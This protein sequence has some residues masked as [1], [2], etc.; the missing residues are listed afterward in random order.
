[1]RL[2]AKL[3]FVFLAVVMLMTAVGSYFSVRRGFERFERRQQQIARETADAIDKRLAEAW[4]QGGV[5]NLLATMQSLGL[6]DSPHRAR[7]V[8]FEQTQIGSGDSQTTIFEQRAAIGGGTV[9]KTF[10]DEHGER[11]LRTYYPIELG[12]SPRGGLEITGSLEPL[13]AA[14]RETIVTALMSLGSMAI[15]CVVLVYFA[16]VRWVAK[17]LDRLIVKTERIGRGDFSDPLPVCGSDELSQ[18]ARALNDMSAKLAEQQQRIHDESAERLATLEQLRHADRLKT[19]GRL[20]AGLAHELGTPLNV[21]SGRAGLIA[22]GKLSVDEIT[23]SANTIKSEADRVTAT[24]RQLLDFARPSKSQRMPVDL[25]ELLCQTIGLLE[26]LAENRNVQ[27][28]ITPSSGLIVSADRSQMLQV[29]TNLLVNAVQSMSA[30]GTIT[31]SVKPCRAKSAGKE[32]A[33][34]RNCVAVMIRDQGT[35]IRPEDLESI[36]EPFFTTKDVGEGTGL[37]LSI[38]YGIVQEHGGWIEVESEPERGSCFTVYLPQ[39]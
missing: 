39:E 19:V 24:I 1:M 4:R 29:F 8:W 12:D 11:H 15:V 27:I 30:G 16:G 17:P 23:S 36:F 22:S 13:D 34:E 28:D 9:S 26:P 20:A 18:L 33:D 5:D 35:G 3:M 37:G 38:A 21:M 2:A 31:A 25:G 32:T 7:W 6:Q 14:A 10:T